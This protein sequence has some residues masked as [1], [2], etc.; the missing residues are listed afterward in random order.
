MYIRGSR[1]AVGIYRHLRRAVHPF[2]VD[3]S[4]LLLHRAVSSF[5]GAAL[6]DPTEYGFYYAALNEVLEGH[7]FRYACVMHVLLYCR[8]VSIVVRWMV[9]LLCC[10]VSGH[11]VE[12]YLCAVIGGATS[13]V[14]LNLFIVGWGMY[15]P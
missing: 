13:M 5:L 12:F 4:N 7:R 3:Y 1:Y 2:L 8:C 15:L 11:Y 10:E 14:G 6:C 9:V